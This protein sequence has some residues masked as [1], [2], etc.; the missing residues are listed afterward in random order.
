MCNRYENMKKVIDRMGYFKI[1]DYVIP[2]TNLSDI[3]GD[4]APEFIFRFLS[5]IKDVRIPKN[6]LMNYSAWCF[7]EVDYVNSYIGDKVYDDKL[8]KCTNRL[9]DI[10]KFIVNKEGFKPSKETNKGHISIA[11]SRYNDG[12]L[13]ITY[14][15]DGV[16][17][18]AIKGKY[19]IKTYKFDSSS[20]ILKYE[21]V[22]DDLESNLK[23][24]VLY[25]N[26]LCNTFAIHIYGLEKLFFDDCCGDSVYLG[27]MSGKP[28]AYPRS[29]ES[30]GT[31]IYSIGIFV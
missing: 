24:L 27:V 12:F 9:I 31:G 13:D 22:I 20:D 18:V 19:N 3:A 17:E 10:G 26:D 30:M 15:I 7:N 14:L 28:S 5:Y 23:D 11:N 1:G 29:F 16:E 6:M 8:V 25:S 4:G 2:L 21:D